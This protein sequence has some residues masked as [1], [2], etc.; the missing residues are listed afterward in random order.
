MS[1]LYVALSV[2]TAEPLV[3]LTLTPVP[4]AGRPGGII[5]GKLQL[6]A[7]LRLL[8]LALAG[9]LGFLL[10]GGWRQYRDP[11][12]LLAIVVDCKRGTVLGRFYEKNAVIDVRCNHNWP[13][14]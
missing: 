10:A 13:N 6:S 2:L 3:Y 11:K 8:L 7:K 1:L 9:A 4:N 12:L 5:P 14:A